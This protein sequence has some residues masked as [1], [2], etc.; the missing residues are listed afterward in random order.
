MY[1]VEGKAERPQHLGGTWEGSEDIPGEAWE[2]RDFQVAALSKA[3]SCIYSC[4]E[5]PSAQP[6]PEMHV[7]EFIGD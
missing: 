2:C 6:L 1:E 3:R 7:C 4:N 5:N